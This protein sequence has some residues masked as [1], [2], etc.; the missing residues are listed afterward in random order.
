MAKSQ[1]PMPGGAINVQIVS[2]K[3]AWNVLIVLTNTREKDS[4]K[5]P[6]KIE[7]NVWTEKRKQAKKFRRNLKNNCF[8]CKIC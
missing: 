3:I 1:K 4:E 7:E 6:A 2:K 8:L 5:K